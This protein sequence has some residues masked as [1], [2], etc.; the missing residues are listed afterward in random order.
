M[1]LQEQTL[2]AMEKRARA[3][4]AEVV[5]VDVRAGATSHD[6]ELGRRR[7]VLAVSVVLA[8]PSDEDSRYRVEEVGRLLADDAAA[9]TAG[10]VKA[11]RLAELLGAALHPDSVEPP[12]R[13]A[14]GW[15][16]KQGPSPARSWP[17][18]WSRKVWRPEGTNHDERGECLVEA[19]SANKARH[20]ASLEVIRGLEPPFK[21]TLTCR[22]TGAPSSTYYVADYPAAAPPRDSLRRLAREGRPL[23]ALLR[24]MLA[25]SPALTPLDR[26]VA[27]EHAFLVDIDALAPVGAFCRGE[28]S[29]GELDLALGPTIAASKP[30]WSCPLA[31]REAHANGQSMGPVLRAHHRE[32]G[33]TIQL[34]LAIRDA[35]GLSLGA[36]KS[37]VGTA[38]DGL[39]DD[40]ITSSLDA[41]LRA[42]A[43]GKSG[44]HR[45]M[46]A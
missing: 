6:P 30:R 38:C 36:A 13:D 19:A 32:V 18:A 27:V 2:D 22:D 34:I 11:R 46:G 14:P 7:D 31:L 8:A 1:A 40:E 33:G 41:E 37:L 23:S 43:A 12:P 20:G 4:G 39:H 16:A 24:G 3:F 28:L 29:D 5:A 9:A 44:G 35:F 21:F 25:E 42:I 17:V 26:M 10:M 15:L 45:A